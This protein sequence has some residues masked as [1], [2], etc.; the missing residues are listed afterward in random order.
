MIFNV[1]AGTQVVPPH[2][3]DQQGL[4]AEWRRAREG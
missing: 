2:L 4:A 1:R 3:R